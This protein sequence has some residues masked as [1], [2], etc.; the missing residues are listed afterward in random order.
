MLTNLRGPGY[1]KLELCLNDTDFYLMD[2]LSDISHYEFFS[3]RCSS[4]GMIYGFNINS[5]Y[6]LVLNGGKNNPY[7]RELL[8]KNIVKNVNKIIRIS[9]MIGQPIIFLAK[10]ND[11]E[12]NISREKQ[13]ELEVI[14]IFQAIDALGNITNHTWFWTLSQIRLV[15]F[16]RYLKDIWSYRA[17]LSYSMKREICPPNGDPFFD[18]DFLSLPNKTTQNLRK[19]S[20]DIMNRMIMNGIND[21]AKSLG[22]N[23]ILCALTLVSPE[24]AQDLPWLYDAVVGQQY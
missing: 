23:Y 11:Q 8:P 13:L 22:A 20:I 18:V 14:N 12:S 7:T 17:Q 19:Y 10:D 2:N 9:Y 15:R 24:A 4:D 21:G 3:Y 6:K 5:I 16:I 1:N